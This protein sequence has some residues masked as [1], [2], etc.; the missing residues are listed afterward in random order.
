MQLS[1]QK[2]VHTGWKPKYTSRQAVELATKAL[3][4]ENLEFAK[5]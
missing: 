1:I 4:K 3:I 5:V 2:L